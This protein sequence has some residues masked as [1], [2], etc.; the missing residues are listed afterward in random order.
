MP[1]DESWLFILGMPRTITFSLFVLILV[2]ELVSGSPLVPE[3]FRE[4][5]K[6]LVFIE[7]YTQREID[8]QSGEGIGLVI[9]EGGLVVCLGNVFGDWVP[10]GK[11]KDIKVFAA[12]NPTGEGFPATYLGQDWVTGWHYLKINDMEE[13]GNWLTSIT[14]FETGR[15]E[16]GEIVWG[17][18]ITPGDLDYIPYYRDGKLSTIQPLPLDTGFATGEVAVPGGPVF[19]EDGRFAGWA[20]RSLPME[21]DI[22]VGQDYF[23]ANIRNPDESLMFILAEPFFNEVFQRVPSDPLEHKRPWIGISGTQ[24]LDKETARFMGL[25]GQGVI[26]VSEVLEDTPASRAGLE[27]RDLVIGINGETL[28]RLKPDSVVQVYFERAILVSEIGEPLV[29]TVLRGEEELDIE[30]IPENSPVL[31]KEAKL[32][33]FNE[34]G[35]TLREFILG[36]ALQRREDHR[37]LKGVV[38]NFIRPNSPAAAGDVQPSD[39]IQEI[40]GEPVAGFEEAVSRLEELSGNDL[41]EEIVLLVRRGTETAV[42]RIRKSAS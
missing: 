38:V 16:I 14:E 19:L 11:F 32:K 7:Y 3:L 9:S 1:C 28:P 8:R 24:P 36:D 15:P 22:W 2:S 40:G 34:I 42:L 12:S 33:Y 5:S 6:T 23:R 25:T 39:W 4:R 20:G 13:A 26:I 27:D 31:M 21:R 37:D 18:C 41:V 30:I 10:P 35:L 17:V 29:L